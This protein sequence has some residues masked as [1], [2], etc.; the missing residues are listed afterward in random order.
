MSQQAEIYSRPTQNQKPLLQDYEWL[1]KFISIILHEKAAS[2]DAS[3][4]TFKIYLNVV[5]KT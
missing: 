3:I 5:Y 4:K 2:A 1:F